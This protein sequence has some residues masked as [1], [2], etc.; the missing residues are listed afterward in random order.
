MSPEAERARTFDSTDG[1]SC[2]SC[3]GPASNWL[4]PHTTKGWTHER[5]VA[6]GMRDLRDPVRRAENCLTCHL[7]TAD[8]SVDHEMIAAGHPDLYFELASFTAAMPRHWKARA[9]IAQRPLADV[10]MLAAG[11]AVQFREQLQR[12]A[13]NAQGTPGPNLPIWIASRAITA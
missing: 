5:S 13:R 9:T 10:R 12:V 1:V 7:G 2:E 4:G 8:K 11:Q 6:A 3:H